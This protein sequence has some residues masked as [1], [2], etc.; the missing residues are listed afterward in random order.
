MAEPTALRTDA[1]EKLLP[2]IVDTVELTQRHAGE[3]SL[4]HRQAVVQL[5]NQLKERFSEA[6]K[7]AQSLPGGDLSIEQQDAL[8]E[9][10]E[11]FRDERM[12]VAL[13]FET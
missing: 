11:R 3:N 9:L 8:I 6:K 10:L 13:S 4:Q 5:A 7:I 2:T 12:S 1:F